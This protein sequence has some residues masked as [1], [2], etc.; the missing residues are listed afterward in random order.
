[1][2]TVHGINKDFYRIKLNNGFTYLSFVIDI[3]DFLHNKLKV[4]IPW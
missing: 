2:N 1:M 4:I 3:A